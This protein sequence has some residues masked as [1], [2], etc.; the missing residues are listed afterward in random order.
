[1]YVGDCGS[2]SH[3]SPHESRWYASRVPG[4][5]AIPYATVPTRNVPAGVA[6]SPSRLWLD[7]PL[8]PTRALHAAAAGVQQRPLRCQ[9]RSDPTV[10]RALAVSTV[11][12]CVAEP[13]ELS[14]F[15]RSA[16]Q[17]TAIRGDAAAV[18]AETAS[19]AT[20]V[21]AQWRI[22]RTTLW[23]ICARSASVRCSSSS[24]PAG[25]LCRRRPFTASV[26]VVTRSELRYS[27]RA[28][29]PVAPAQLRLV[30]LRHWGFDGRAHTGAIVVNAAVA[31]AVVDVFSQLYR[32]RF[33]IRRMEPVDAFHGSDP[34]SMAAD[35][36]SA[37]N[38]RY[39][40]APGAKHWSV[41]AYGEAIDVNP[42]ENPY[43]EGGVVR[44]PAGRVYVNRT[45]VRP[46]MAVRG[47]RLVAAFAAAGW[48]WQA[49]QRFPRLPALLCDRGMSTAA[50]LPA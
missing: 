49:A 50:T 21:A 38:C 26:S 40:V 1:M 45:R 13:V 29:C 42:V 9:S 33:P 4:F 28:G 41:H 8:L 30:K 20:A 37:F 44:P 24:Q 32:A 6:P 36:T 17:P 10:E 39:A 25:R 11:I 12:S 15:A 22:D 5:G 47:G 43:L 3:Q 7:T 19:I 27:Y 35:N 2:S 14:P 16:A 18:A 34:R 23:T 46:G 31:H 48:Q